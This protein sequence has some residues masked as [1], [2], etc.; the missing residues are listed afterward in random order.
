MSQTTAEMTA[1]SPEAFE[2]FLEARD[3]PGWLSDQ[4]RQ[5][6]QIFCE[7]EL[8]KRSEEEWMRTDI[9]LFKLNKFGIPSGDGGGDAATPLLTEGVDLGGQN[10]SINGQSGASTIQAQWTEKGLIFGNLADVAREHSELVKEHL[11]QGVVDPHFDK[12]SALHAS[13][14]TSGTFLYVPRGVTVDQPF[15]SLATISGHGVD[16]GHTLVVVEEWSTKVIIVVSSK[17]KSSIVILFDRRHRIDI[18]LLLLLF[19]PFS[20]FGSFPLGRCLGNIGKLISNNYR[21]IFWQTFNKFFN[22]WYFILKVMSGTAGKIG[23]TLFP[24]FLG[25]ISGLWLDVFYNLED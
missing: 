8:P 23:K 14:W 18:V 6:W 13:C 17:S 24:P 5:A 1:F 7:R 3:E 9:R 22:F 2:A 25:L 11:F 10:S 20:S 19:A 16:L 15:H 4:R 12:F 21:C